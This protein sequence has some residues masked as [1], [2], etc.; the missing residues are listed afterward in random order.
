MTLN[1]DP[2]PG[3]LLTLISPPC[4]VAQCPLKLGRLVMS[5]CPGHGTA[6]KVGQS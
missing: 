5:V 2:T 1:V 4:A 3:L 6:Q